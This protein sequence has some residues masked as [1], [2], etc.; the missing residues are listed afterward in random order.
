MLTNNSTTQNLSI[1]KKPGALAD[2]S[3]EII[4]QQILDLDIQPGAQLHIEIFAEKLDVS[5]TPLREALQRLAS[6]GLVEIRPRVGYFVSDITEQ[7]IRDL[8]EIREI[9][10]SRAAHRAAN[11]LTDKEMEILKE[12]NK[13]TKQAVAKGDYNDFLEKEISFHNFLHKHIEN[14]HLTALVET[15]NNLTYRE[16]IISIKSKENVEATVLEHQ[17]IIDALLNRDADK[18]AWY[19]AEHLKNVSDRIVKFLIEKEKI[20]E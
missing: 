9:I 18:A 14:E 19:M 6:E 17:R 4:K 1:P 15:L 11:D 12:M 20:Y 16:R 5:R 10:E 7:D 13:A 3:Y 2:W 8:L